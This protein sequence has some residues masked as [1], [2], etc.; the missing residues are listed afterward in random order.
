VSILE[1][2]FPT[3]YNLPYILYLFILAIIAHFVTDNVIQVVARR[4]LEEKPLYSN[5]IVSTYILEYS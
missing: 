2:S 1:L 3:I 4:F 5:L